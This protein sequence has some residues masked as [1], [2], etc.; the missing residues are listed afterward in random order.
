MKR[1]A[2][3]CALFFVCII[4]VLI[5]FAGS[6]LFSQH[7]GKARMKGKVTGQDG[8][9]IA[10]VNVKLYSFRA[11]STMTTRTDAKG[12]WKAMWVRGGKWNIDFEKS[13]FAPKKISSNLKEDTKITFIETTLEAVKGPSI[14]KEMMKDFEKA[15]TLFDAKKID[16][17]LAVYEKIVTE[18]PD[19]YAIYLNIGNCYFEKEDYPK[20]IEAYKK[21]A[22]KEPKNTGIILSIGNSY[23]N[24]KK[25]PEALDWY[26]KIEVEKITD[27]VVLYNIGV[28]NFNAGKIEDSLRFFKRSTEVKEDFKDGWYQLGMC[29]M[30]VAKNKEAI[31]AFEKY[32]QLDPDSQQARQVK[33][34]LKALKQT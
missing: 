21:V 1:K 12:E 5:V 27:P 8:N 15:N 31:A 7:Q 19:A 28:F 26:D 18:F 29:Y 25:I 13:G 2:L 4:A 23:S 17:A 6:P 33:E 14:K 10:G 22:E 9:P 34:I 11:D 16:Q 24:M 30:S 20:A 32:L 3:F